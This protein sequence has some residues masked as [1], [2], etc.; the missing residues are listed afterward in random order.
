MEVESVDADSAAAVAMGAA[1][2]EKNTKDRYRSCVADALI[3]FREKRPNCLNQNNTAFTIPIPV[4]A[5]IKFFGH[6]CSIAHERS[7]MGDDEELDPEDVEPPP[8]SSVSLYRSALFDLYRGA[9]VPVP[10]ATTLQVKKILDGY[11]KLINNLR[12]R[13]LAPLSEGKRD[14]QFG[15]YCMMSKK[16]MK[17][18]PVERHVGGSWATTTFVWNF[19]VLFWNLMS[20]SDSVQSLMLSHI[21]SRKDCIVF[22]EQGHKGDQTGRKKFW[23]HVYA[24]LYTY[25]YTYML[26]LCRFLARSKSHIPLYTTCYLSLICWVT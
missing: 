21:E 15:G 19:F 5:L 23:K 25:T 9:D 3:W 2:T 16:F 26:R 4:D 22:Q 18:D 10:P 1:V 14:L 17:K 13:G 7:K 20:R 8:L 24:I 11:K 12:K 6:L